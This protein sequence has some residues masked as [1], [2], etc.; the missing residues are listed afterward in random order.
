MRFY[1]RFWTLTLSIPL[2][3]NAAEEVCLKQPL[4][5]VN[6]ITT[7]QTLPSRYRTTKDL[8]EREENYAFSLEGLTELGA[9]ASS[10]F[11]IEELRALI[12]H[13][14]LK[15]LVI[16]DLRKESH[17]YVNNYAV[18]WYVPKNW[19]NKEKS[20]DDIFNDERERLGA[21]MDRREIILHKIVEKAYGSSYATALK[22]PVAAHYVC[23]EEELCT[24]FN[25]GY[26]RAV[27]TDHLR[28]TDEVVDHFI[29]AIKSLT[30]NQWPHFHCKSG[31]GRATT[32]MTL[33]DMIHNADKIALD[34]IIKRQWALG[35][36]NLFHFPPP[37]SWKY[38]HFLE[39][40]EFLMKFYDYCRDQAPEFNVPWS[41]WTEHRKESVRKVEI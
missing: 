8:F 29:L 40:K 31:Q 41:Y 1:W 39:R 30:D 24:S 17:G 2:M 26:V 28:P 35:G 6:S 33:Y 21:I 12:E 23:T 16:F 38:L 27:V 15:N 20:L 5:I 22:L 7:S 36:I 3:L 19:L 37:T 9:S 32:F 10:Q 11:S 4:L 14:P 13:L 34:D 25:L 18:S